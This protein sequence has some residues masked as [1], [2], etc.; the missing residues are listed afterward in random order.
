MSSMEGGRG[1]GYFLEK[2]IPI[3]ESGLIRRSD[4]HRTQTT[5]KRVGYFDQ[6]KYLHCAVLG[7][8]VHTGIVSQKCG[9]EE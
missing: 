3:V 9:H 1:C 7:T 8:Q 5:L 4:E 2:P 6:Q